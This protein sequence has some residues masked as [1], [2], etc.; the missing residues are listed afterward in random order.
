MNVMEPLNELD[1]FEPQIRA[2]SNT[3]PLPRP[4][5]YV[6]PGD[7]TGNKCSGLPVQTTQNAAASAAAANVPAKRTPA[8]GTHGAILHKMP[9][10]YTKKTDRDLPEEN[11]KQ[12][13]TDVLEGNMSARGSATKNNV[14]KSRLYRANYSPEGAKNCGKER[15]T[16]SWSSYLAGTWRTRYS[17]R[18]YIGF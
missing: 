13:I 12:A 1:G 14:T 3:W 8:V 7:E 17:G 2:R 9:R 18:H 10:I 16:S 6:E 11:M 4:E 15:R 5:N